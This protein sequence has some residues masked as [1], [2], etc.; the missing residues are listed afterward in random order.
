MSSAVAV[1]LTALQSIKLF[2]IFK[3]PIMVLSWADVKYHNFTWRMLRALELEAKALQHLQPDKHEW[4]QR[5]GIQVMDLIDMVVFP[6][7]PLTDFGV[8]LAE[9]WQMRCSTCTLVSMG[10]TFEHLIAK[11]ITPQIMGAFSLPLSDWTELGFSLQHA[12]AMSVEDCQ[13]VFGIQKKE[14]LHLL[15][16]FLKPQSVAQ[17]LSAGL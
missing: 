16:T 2:G 14:F 10:V 9:L 11:G 3:Q 17:K 15:C 12:E 7:N 8:D 5:G 13:L 6:V 4:L 1:P